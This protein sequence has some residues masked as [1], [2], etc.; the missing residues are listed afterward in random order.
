MVNQSPG[1]FGEG[2][3]Q[4][5][6][7]LAESAEQCMILVHKFHTICMRIYEGNNDGIYD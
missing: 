5:G 4:S 7:E 2:R 3:I 1:A 6:S